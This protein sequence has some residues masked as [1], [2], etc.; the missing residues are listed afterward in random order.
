MDR[1]YKKRL[2]RIWEE[3]LKY[4]QRTIDKLDFSSWFDY[5]HTHL[6]W[7][8]QGNKSPEIRAIVAKATYQ[9]LIYAENASSSRTE[10]IQIF[11]QIHEDTGENSV[12]IHSANP[13]GTDFP[14]K[15]DYIN[16][17]AETPTELIGVVNQKTHEIGEFR[18]E[19]E[20]VYVIRKRA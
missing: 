5:W 15:F 3:N 4:A 17:S 9:L 20:C 8:S 11:A 13:N 1:R 18:R 14:C 12:L 19:S 16:W 2:E 6:D 7:R 10:P